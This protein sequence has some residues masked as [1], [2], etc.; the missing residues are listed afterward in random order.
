[1][2]LPVLNEELNTIL[3]EVTESIKKLYGSKLKKIILYGSYAMGCQD[4]ESDIDLMVLID[5]D[6]PQLRNYDKKLNEIISDI[7]YR[8]LKVLSLIDM[9]YEKYNKWVDVVPYYKNVKNQGVVVYEQKIIALSKYRLEKAKEDLTASRINLENGLIKASINRSYYA[10]F[11]SIRAVNALNEFDSKKH[12]G[13]IAHFNQF[14]IHTGYFEKEIYPLITSAFKL[15]E[16]S[17]YDDF[18]CP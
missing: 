14:F 4:E 18:H 6:E 17:D 10:I 2:D 5:M 9:S 16:K 15:R 11:H 1:M 8:H 12:S 3:S 7:G 13:V